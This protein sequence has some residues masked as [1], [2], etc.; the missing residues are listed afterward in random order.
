MWIHL[1]I[2]AALQGTRI[3]TR[4]ERWTY[5]VTVTELDD[6]DVAT[7][8][9]LL[10]G[11][12]VDD[13]DADGAATRTELARAD[14]VSPQLGMDGRLVS[15]STPDFARSLP[16]RLL[17]LRLPRNR[18]EVHDEWQDPDLVRRFARLLPAE[19]E[20]AL[21]GTARL[22]ELGVEDTRPIAVLDTHATA[23][24]PGGP[25]LSLEGRAHWDCA[26]GTLH[27]RTLTAR[28]TPGGD[29]PGVLHLRSCLVADQAVILGQRRGGYFRSLLLA[30]VERLRELPVASRKEALAR[31]VQRLVQSLVGGRAK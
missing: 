28:F 20:L 22:A 26:R 31:E 14:P 10:T 4:A 17:G 3:H 9:G 13:P 8:E 30:L 11:L 19:G 27:R 21:T 12:G 7:L 23:A 25:R 1:G 2:A 24:L 29:E 16:H 18:V 5:L 6:H 15:C